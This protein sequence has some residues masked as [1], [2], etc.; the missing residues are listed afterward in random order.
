MDKKEFKLNG[1]EIAKS[2][3]RYRSVMSLLELDL[4]LQVLVLPKAIENILLGSGCLRVYDVINLDLAKIKG[5]GPRRL[6]VLRS[7]LNEFV[8]M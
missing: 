5:I 7:R 3:S 1:D 4:P 6:T 2:V 8:P